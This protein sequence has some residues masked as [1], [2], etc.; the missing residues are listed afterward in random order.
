MGLTDSTLRRCSIGLI[1]SYTPLAGRAE[2][3]NGLPCIN[4]IVKANIMFKSLIRK[5]H[6]FNTRIELEI[7][8]DRL[9]KDFFRGEEFIS[10]QE[11]VSV[12]E[13]I[14]GPITMILAVY[15]SRAL[16]KYEQ[17]DNKYYIT[18]LLAEWEAQRVEVTARLSA[19]IKNNI[20][21]E[22]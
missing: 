20:N 13:R 5:I 15:F 9:V 6:N 2:E 21:Q 11:F 10:P 7:V 17:A 4:Y 1:P 22:K 19:H 14:H 12:M 8:A 3:L 16:A 18:I